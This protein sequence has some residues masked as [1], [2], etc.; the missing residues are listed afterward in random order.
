MNIILAN[1]SKLNYPERLKVWAQRQ[2]IVEVTNLAGVRPGYVFEL[3]YEVIQFSLNLNM[4][5]AVFTATQRTA[6]VADTHGP[7]FSGVGGWQL[8]KMCHCRN[9]GGNIMRQSLMSVPFRDKNSVTRD[10]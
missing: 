8:K 2:S 7:A 10:I 9:H 1:P 3:L 5:F 6:Q 4:E